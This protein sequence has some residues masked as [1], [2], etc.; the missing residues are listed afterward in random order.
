[1]NRTAAHGLL[2]AIAVSPCCAQD[3]PGYTDTPKIP[4]QEW[5]VHDAHRPRPPAIDP[6]PAP[7][8]P[9]PVPA[10]AI[11]LLGDDLDAWTGRDDKA[12]WTVADGAATVNGTGD[13]RT[14]ESFGSMQLHIEWATPAEVKGK[15]QGRGNSGVFLMGRYEV[16]ILDSYE[17]ESYA[18]GQ[19]AA[20]YG[21]Y[22]PMVNACRKP[23]EWQ[24]Y[25]IVFM[26]PVFEGDALVEPARLT[27]FHNGILVHHDRAYLGGTAHKRA[28]NY[29]AH[30]NAPLQLQDHG[31]PVRFRNI[32]VRPL[33]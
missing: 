15:S 32:W 19:A 29:R 24:S 2:A 12:S 17:N 31:N 21:Q 10:D 11:V 5:R 7:S 27:V 9:A 33:D 8:A 23:G 25:D 1:M 28:P 14:R 30:G 3:P 6:G 16:Q 26:A 18:D 22:P 4:G 20:M 13:I